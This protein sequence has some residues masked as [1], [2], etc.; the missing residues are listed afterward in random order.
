MGNPRADDEARDLILFSGPCD[1]TSARAVRDRIALIPRDVLPQLLM[2]DCQLVASELVSNA[3][4][5][6]SDWIDVDLLLFGDY[7]ELRVRDEAAGV[8]E[9]QDSSDSD[10]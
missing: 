8:P 9:L 10:P 3:F 4:R 2:H 6:R 1:A 7:I 5:A